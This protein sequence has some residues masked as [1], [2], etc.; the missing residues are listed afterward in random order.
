MFNS[1]IQL[2]ILQQHKD[3]WDTAQSQFNIGKLWAK[4]KRI[5]GRHLS[6]PELFCMLKEAEH[7]KRLFLEIRGA[8]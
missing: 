3:C 2:W 1:T 4:R 7:A 6:D 8:A 5:L